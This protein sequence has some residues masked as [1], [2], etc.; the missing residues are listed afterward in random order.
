MRVTRALT[1]DLAIGAALIAIGT[2]VVIATHDAAP[3]GSR[4]VTM[5]GAIV[6][7][8]ILVARS[9]LS[10][11][12]ISRRSALPGFGL[13]MGITVTYLSLLVLLPLSMVFIKATQQS[14]HQLWKTTWRQHPPH[15]FC[16]NNPN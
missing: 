10:M 6:L 3:N 14:P 13:S 16:P 11:T 8:I 12:R 2:S 5:W 1:R 15:Q 4:F 9:L 7:G